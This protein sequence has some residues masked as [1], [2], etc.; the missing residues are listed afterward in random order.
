MIHVAEDCYVDTWPIAGWYRDRMFR[1]V[2]KTGER[3]ITVRERHPKWAMHYAE[4]T[5]ARDLL[6]FGIQK[7]ISISGIDVSVVDARNLLDFL[8]SRKASGYPYYMWK[9]NRD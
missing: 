7:C 8:N 4:R 9:S 6:R 1:V 3:N 5:L 2:D